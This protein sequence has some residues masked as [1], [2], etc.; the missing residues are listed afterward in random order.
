M[1]KPKSPISIR[2][3][4]VM[5]SQVAG[6]KGETVFHWPYVNIMDHEGAQKSRQILDR[7]GAFKDDRSMALIAAMV[8]EAYIDRVL[9]AIM[10]GYA[11][12][13]SRSAFAAKI[14]ILRAL[15]LIPRHL[16]DAADL[17]R[18]VRNAF[19]HDLQLD[20]LEN[21]PEKYRKRLFGF[22]TS[23]N[24]VGD[25]DDC[26]ITFDFAVTCATSGIASFYVNAVDFNAAIRNQAFEEALST[27]NSA[28]RQMHVEAYM[29]FL[30]SPPREDNDHDSP[31]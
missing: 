14:S 22:A 2:L 11:K 30:S 7:L 10:P 21:I 29:N 27:V 3:S 17:V 26:R 18:D 24:M 23:R 25:R 1:A 19:G 9:S 13:L 16:A 15:D 20:S 8:S 12:N 4:E 6:L 28:R 5:Q 31:F